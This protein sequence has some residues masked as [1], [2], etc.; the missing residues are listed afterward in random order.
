MVLAGVR[1]Q[2]SQRPVTS[3]EVGQL[4]D[5][6]QELREAR[7]AELAA[8]R[9]TLMHELAQIERQ[10]GTSPTN[11]QIRHAYRRCGGVCPECGRKLL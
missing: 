11:A 8:R 7:V 6:L 1:V 9:D 2:V 4:A 3:E 10:L 5:Q